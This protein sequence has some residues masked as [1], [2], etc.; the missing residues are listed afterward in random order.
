M[1]AMRISLLIL[2]VLFN[3]QGFTQTNWVIDQVHSDIRFTITHMMISEVDGEFKEFEAKVSS[4]SDEF[5]GSN[6]TF[7]AKV[8]SINTDNERRDGHLK[9]E[10]FFNAEVHPEVNFEG[11]IQKDGEKYFLVGDLT[12]KNITHQVRFDVKYNGQI[13]GGSG[14]KAGFKVTGA[15]DRFDYG[16]TWNRTIE[17]GGLIVSKEVYITCNVQLNEVVN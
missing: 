14:K 13:A 1:K 17:S 16:L 2:G 4:P 7:I 11:K 3:F 10:D 6:V 15:I 9:S 12:M 5:D 8:A